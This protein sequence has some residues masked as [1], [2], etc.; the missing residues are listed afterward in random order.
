MKWY[1]RKALFRLKTEPSGNLF[2]AVFNIQF[3]EN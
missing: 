1:G 3:A 2:Y